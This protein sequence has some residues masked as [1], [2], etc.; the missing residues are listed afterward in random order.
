MNKKEQED[1]RLTASEMDWDELA[2]T[3]IDFQIEKDELKQYLTNNA[4]KKYS[5][6]IEIYEKEKALRVKNS[7]NEYSAYKLE[8][9]EDFISGWN[10]DE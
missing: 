2:E 10:N 7:K 1:H 4:L 6:L 8:Y 9:G 5:I 3:I